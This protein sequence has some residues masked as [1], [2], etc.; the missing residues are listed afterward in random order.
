M[1][2]SLL[3]M[4][5]TL[6]S[7]CSKKESTPAPVESLPKISIN[8][9]TRPEGNTALNEFNFTIS[10]SKAYSKVVSV[11]YSTTEGFAKATED[12]NQSS[13]TISFQPGETQKSIS[14]AVIGDDMKEGNDDFKIILSGAVN[15]TIG[16]STGLAVIENDDKR[17]AFSNTGYDA[18]TTYP[19]Y[20]LSWADEFN[21]TA[22]DASIWSFENGDGC[23]NICG[24]GNNELEYYTNRPDNLFFFRMGK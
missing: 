15:A 17:V 14:I 11:N 1:Q 19:G 13:Q 3:M 6:F 12:F 4:A 16:K 8:D 24:W 5:F 18:P 10:L 23:P 9:L 7:N 21:G 22:L 20:T 2:L